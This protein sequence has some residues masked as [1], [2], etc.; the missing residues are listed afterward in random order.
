MG[1]YKVLHLGKPTHKYWDTATKKKVSTSK[2]KRERYKTFLCQ[3][4]VGI[5]NTFLKLERRGLLL[6]RD[7][8]RCPT[9][10]G[11][12]LTL[13]Y[14]T[15]LKNFATTSPGTKKKAFEVDNCRQYYKAL[16]CHQ[17]S[18]FFKLV[19]RGLLLPRDIIRCSNI[20]SDEG[21][22]VFEV[23]NLNLV[24]LDATVVVLVILAHVLFNVNLSVGLDTEEK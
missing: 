18:A 9:K 1:Y 8:E 13:K 4:S 12:S 20:T 11:S 16:L 17:L 10:E 24:A 22:K 21:K 7:I 5:L 15:R 2:E 6:P 19:R 3:W 23:G 14:R